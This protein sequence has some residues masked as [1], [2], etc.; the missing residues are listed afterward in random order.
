MT[1]DKFKGGPPDGVLKLNRMV[2]EQNALNN[3]RGDEQFITVRKGGGSAI[4]YLNI[5]NVLARVPRPPNNQYEWYVFG[6]SDGATQPSQRWLYAGAQKGNYYY[7]VMTGCIVDCVEV[8]TEGRDVADTGKVI[9]NVYKCTAADV[10]N[11]NFNDYSQLAYVCTQT[12]TNQ[13]ARLM[14]NPSVTLDAGEGLAIA[15]EAGTPEPSTWDFKIMARIRIWPNAVATPNAGAHIG[16][17][18]PVGSAIDFG[19]VSAVT[20]VI[21]G[22][23]LTSDGDPAVTTPNL[24]GATFSN[25]AFAFYSG[26]TGDPNAAMPVGHSEV[27]SLTFDP[28]GLDSGTYGAALIFTSDI[29]NQPEIVYLLTVLYARPATHLTA[30]ASDPID[31]GTVTG[32]SDQYGAI[33]ILADGGALSAAAHLLGATF[34]NPAFSF[35]HGD[36]HATLNDGDSVYFDMHFASA[37]LAAGVQTGT[38]TIATDVPGQE[39]LVFNITADYEPEEGE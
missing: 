28:T 11:G 22:I 1:L 30:T 13:A 2:D 27:F 17:D 3:I 15:A 38:V 37:G 16:G 39:S 14:L 26:S 20:N 18:P 8:W 35:S 36:D 31:F 29:P 9:F 12:I 19:S 21:D 23:T 5:N 7:P 33:V 24:T 4:I 32:D 6:C 10:Q 25:P 34:S